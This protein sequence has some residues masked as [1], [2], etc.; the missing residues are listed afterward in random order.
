MDPS[1]PVKRRAD[2][3]RNIARILDCAA[4]LLAEDRSAGMVEIA[5][6]AGVGR[7]TLYRH[8]PTREALI[9]AI[10][11]RA[12]DEA[13]RAV[14]ASRLDEGPVTEALRR[15][16]DALLAVGDRYRVINNVGASDPDEPRR[17]RE[18]ALAAPMFDLVERGQREGELAPDLPP[19]LILAL[20]GTVLQT[21][22]RLVSEGTLTREQASGLCARV[23]LDGVGARPAN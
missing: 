8:F 2:A 20:L 6:A 3:E 10:H 17:A 12:Y 7:A 9:A 5:S 1:T 15:L 21:H 19:R 4:R 14:A 23:L 22:I 18:E 16:L 11:L 13:E